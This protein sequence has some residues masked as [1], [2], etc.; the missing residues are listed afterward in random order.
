MQAEEPNG[1]GDDERH[2]F[3]TWWAGQINLKKQI[4]T[5]C[6]KYRPAAVKVSINPHKLV[7]LPRENL[8]YCTNNRVPAHISYHHQVKTF[9]F[10]RRVVPL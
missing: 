5:T 3:D 2:E 6:A 10:L 9:V 8:L 1:R 7:Y 4:Q